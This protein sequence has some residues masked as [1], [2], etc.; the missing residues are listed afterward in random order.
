MEIKYLKN[1]QEVEVVSQF[2]G[3][4]VV[5]PI[6]ERDGEPFAGD[7]KVVKAV[8]DSP[9]ME[10][11]NKDVAEMQSKK[12]DLAKQLDELRTE[13]RAATGERQKLLES[14]KQVPALK[15]IDDFIC[16]RF[17]HI[18]KESY[19]EYSIVAVNSA[20]F[21]T[22]DRSYDREYKLLTLF[23]RTKGDLAFRINQYSDG[24][25]HS[26]ECWLC[27]SEQE[28]KDLIVEKIG[29]RLKETHWFES[30]EKSLTKYGLPISQVITDTI[31]SRRLENAKQAQ[32]KA[33]AELDKANAALAQAT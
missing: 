27:F 2:D 14:I 3:G 8:F 29:N 21:K 11:I 17:T 9:P 32:A 10:R 31:R 12:E 28:A 25:G 20:E 30:Y 15:R 23:G 13:I 22:A 6:Y 33:Q 24:S 4:F 18:V 19:G 1:G 26:C 7:P 16:G 5:N